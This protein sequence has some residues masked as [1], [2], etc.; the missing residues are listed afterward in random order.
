[1]LAKLDDINIVYHCPHCKMAYTGIT[2]LRRNG[3]S[4]EFLHKYRNLITEQGTDGNHCPTCNR[5]MKAK[6]VAELP[7]KPLVEVCKL[8]NFLFLPED[9]VAAIPAEPAHLSLDE[10][11]SEETKERMKR[12]ELEMKAKTPETDTVFST[13]I[14]V[15]QKILLYLFP[16]LIPAP[17]VNRIPIVT[18]IFVTIL[19]FSTLFGSFLYD[20]F[21]IETLSQWNPFNILSDMIGANGV[22]GITSIYLLLMMG[23]KVEDVIGRKAYIWLIALTYILYFGTKLIFQESMLYP[24]GGVMSVFFTILMFFVYLFPGSYIRGYFLFMWYMGLRPYQFP[25]WIFALV[26]GMGIIVMNL[27]FG[28]TLQTLFSPIV[29]GFFLP[30]FFIVFLGGK[31]YIF[32]NLR[33]QQEEKED[34][35]G[36]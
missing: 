14:T 4:E 29:I 8:C 5:V 15:W 23:T 2:L 3:K 35:Y 34:P 11:L 16:R 20:L 30:L 1:M 22:I 33:Y 36:M 25:L 18:Y 24:F 31:K 7:G 10:Q 26:I 28:F 27:A 21:K 17:I 9:S 13:N 32:R 6:T 12:L 19:A